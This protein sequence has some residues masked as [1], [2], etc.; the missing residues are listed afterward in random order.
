MSFF[1]F[2]NGK[3]DAQE[4]GEA[5]A[6]DNKATEP[7]SQT[8]SVSSTLSGRPG[9]YVEQHVCFVCIQQFQSAEHL[10]K[11]QTESLFHKVSVTYAKGD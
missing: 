4:N 8:K 9:L 10:A 1:Q 6:K 3:F 11:H 7:M 2:E 5:K